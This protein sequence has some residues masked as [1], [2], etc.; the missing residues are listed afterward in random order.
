MKIESGDQ[1]IISTKITGQS[2]SIEG[3]VF[4]KKNSRVRYNNDTHKFENIPTFIINGIDGCE[5][6]ATIDDITIIDAENK[7]APKD[8][9]KMA[10]VPADHLLFIY[11]NHDIY[12]ELKKY[13]EDNMDVIESDIEYK[14]KQTN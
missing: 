12:G 6:T 13:I 7:T 9:D 2:M 8:G 5:Y 3:T 1:V 11:H 10:N 4:C 14:N